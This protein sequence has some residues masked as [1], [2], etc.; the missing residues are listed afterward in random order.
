MCVSIK[1][2]S[3]CFRAQITHYGK[4]CMYTIYPSEMLPKIPR[5]IDM[6]QE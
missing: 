1:T 5:N 2:N 4:E 6:Y 3:A